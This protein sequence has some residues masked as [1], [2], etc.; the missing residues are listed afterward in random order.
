[1]GKNIIIACPT[2]PLVSISSLVG[3]DKVQ[4][5]LGG[6]GG[7]LTVSFPYQQGEIEKVS[8]NLDEENNLLNIVVK[9]GEKGLSFRQQDIVF[10][11][12]GKMPT[13][14]FFVGVSRLSDVASLY[15][16]DVHPDVEIVNIDKNPQNEKYGTVAVVDTKWSSVSEQV[17]D[18]VTLLEPQIE[19]DGDTAQ[20]LLNGIVYAT[21]DFVNPGTSYLAFEVA[22]IL[23]KKGAARQKAQAIVTSANNNATPDNT[24]FFPPISQQQSQG[25]VRPQPQF[26]PVQQSTNIQP[27]QQ[28]EQPVQPQSQSHQTP[29]DWLTPKV[30]KGS[31]VL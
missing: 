12:G 8:Y 27:R 11:R 25:Q 29:P 7:D 16:P 4:R 26:Q 30:Y 10:K 1:M 21:Q 28:S 5:N 6:E 20:N 17:A 15:R 24:S 14:L 22:G 3:I 31:T 9:A 23:I 2:D 13:L 19:L 18:F